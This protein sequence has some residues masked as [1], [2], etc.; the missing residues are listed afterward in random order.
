MEQL[1]IATQSNA[2]V[3]ATGHL[4][5]MD[6]IKTG[7]F[8]NILCISVYFLVQISLGEALFHYSDYSYPNNNSNNLNFLVQLRRAT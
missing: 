2:L 7:V 5:I 1:P 8:L 6:M 3:F 4:Q